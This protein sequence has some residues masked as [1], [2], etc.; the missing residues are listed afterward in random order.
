MLQLRAT[1]AES[2]NFIHVEIYQYPFDQLHTAKTVDEWQLPSDPWTFIV[3]KTGIVR[4]RFEGAAP[5]EEL[6]PSLKAV[7]T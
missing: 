3:D 5:I 6:Q 1:Y 2:A 4:D 7:L